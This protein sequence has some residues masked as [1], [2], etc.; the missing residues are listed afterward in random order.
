MQELNGENRDAI[1]ANAGY[2]AALAGIADEAASAGTSLDQNTVAGSANAAMLADVA[3]KAQAAA[4]AQHEVDIAN[5]GS[6]T[7][8]EKYAATLGAQRQAFIDSATAAGCNADEVQALAD[9]VFALPSEREID[10]LAD[11]GQA[12][13]GVNEFIRDYA[14]ASFNMYVNAIGTAGGGGR[15][16]QS[17]AMG[18]LYVGARRRSSPRAGSLSGSTRSRRVGFT[19]SRRR[20]TRRTSASTRHAVTGAWTFGRRPGGCLGHGC[21]RARRRSRRPPHR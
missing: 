15:A 3:S 10:I 13:S 14:G 2:Q 1:S 5:L 11:T 16:M 17:N 12:R 4:E 7:A 21:R 19:N 8:A 18:N 20:T 6:T 9:Q